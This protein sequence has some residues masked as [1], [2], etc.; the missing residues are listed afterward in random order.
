[1]GDGQAEKRALIK[2]APRWVMTLHEALI[3]VYSSFLR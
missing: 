3:R 2:Y 1:M